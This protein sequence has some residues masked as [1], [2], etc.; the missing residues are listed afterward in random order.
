M[1]KSKPKRN[2]SKKL[3]KKPVKIDWASD[4]HFD[5]NLAMIY[6][7]QCQQCFVF[8]Q[9]TNIF[10]E[11]LTEQFPE[12]KFMLLINNV[13]SLGEQAARIGAWE[14]SLAKNARSKS[15]LLWSGFEKGPP[16]REK[17]LNDSLYEDI[18]K[19]V[20]LLLAK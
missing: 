4:E 13:A 3:K 16:R 5:E 14:I 10:F 18:W 7:E 20:T 2:K 12:Q 19:R 1:P 9:Q 8:Q 6:I 11:K 15:E 17:F